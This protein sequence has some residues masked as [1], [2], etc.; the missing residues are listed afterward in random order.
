MLKERIFQSNITRKD[1]IIMRKHFLIIV[2][3]NKQASSIH[4]RGGVNF[5]KVI[6]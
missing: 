3:K 6:C 5:A 2:A 1:D 4:Y